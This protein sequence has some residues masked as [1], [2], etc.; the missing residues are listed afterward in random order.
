MKK[1]LEELKIPYTLQGVDYYVLGNGKEIYVNGNTVY[2]L[3]PKVLVKKSLTQK[4]IKRIVRAYARG[5]RIECGE[6]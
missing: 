4:T 6:W 2:F 1:I 5:K 3:R